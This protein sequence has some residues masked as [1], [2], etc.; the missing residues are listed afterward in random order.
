[1]LAWLDYRV[2]I[3]HIL[4][5]FCLFWHVLTGARPLGICAQVGNTLVYLIEAGLGHLDTLLLGAHKACVG[6]DGFAHALHGAAE[7]SLK[8]FLDLA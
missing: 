5:L 6:G 2:M 3:G 8:L 7:L 1:M 4:F